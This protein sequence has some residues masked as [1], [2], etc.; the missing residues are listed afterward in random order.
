MERFEQAY[1]FYFVDPDS[2]AHGKLVA[3]GYDIISAST[4]RGKKEP[5]QMREREKMRRRGRFVGEGRVGWGN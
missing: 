1:I 4:R 2:S 3:N 5:T